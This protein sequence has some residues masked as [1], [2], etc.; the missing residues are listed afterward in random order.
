VPRTPTAVQR[1]PLGVVIPTF[2]CAG[3]MP[4]HIAA[5]N[6]W[7]DLAQEVVVVDSESTDG[8]LELLRAGLSHPNLRFFTRPRGLYQAWNFGIAQLTA[9]FTYV[10]TAGDT[11]TRDGI[12][13]LFETARRLGSDV[14]MSPPQLIPE[15]GVREPEADWPVHRIIRDLDLRAPVVLRR[16]RVLHFAIDHALHVLGILGSSASNLYRTA[17]LQ[18]RPFPGD[19]GH[20]GDVYW[21]VRHALDAKF[22]LTPKCCSTF[23]IHPVTHTEQQKSF[24]LQLQSRMPQWAEEALREA[25]ANGQPADASELALVHE[26]LLAVTAYIADK[27][28]VHKLRDRHRFWSLYPSVWQVRRTRNQHRRHADALAARLRQIPAVQTSAEPG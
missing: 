24:Y 9:E 12:L 26:Y 27:D 16:S 23:L 10:S 11:I 17:S 21:G 7:L 3:Y 18:A 28:R 13:H 8:T 14:L 20:A 4:A 19:C 2:N 5:L 22:A 1:L 25:G 15:A 6:R